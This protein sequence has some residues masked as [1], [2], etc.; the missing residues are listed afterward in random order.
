M[1]SGLQTECWP[2]SLNPFFIGHN[3]VTINGNSIWMSLVGVNGRGVGVFLKVGRSVN[4]KVR[5]KRGFET[6]RLS[7]EEDREAFYLLKVPQNQ[8]QHLNL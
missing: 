6:V 3:A 2:T 1:A 4:E 7:E 8:S 5:T